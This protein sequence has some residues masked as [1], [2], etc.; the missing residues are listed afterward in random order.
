LS[1]PKPTIL[2]IGG[3]VITDKNGELS[4]K[5]GEIDRLT[6]EIREANVKNLIVVHGGGSFGHPAAERYAIKNGYK[7]ESQKIGFSQT[8]HYMTVLNGL[9]MDALIWHDVPSMS[10]TPSSCIITENGRI[11]SFE[12]A[13]LRTLMKMNFT[14]VLYGDAVFDTKIG[15][16]ILSGDQLVSALAL[17]FNATRIIMGVDEDGVYDAD[18]KAQKTAKLFDH[19]T[20]SELRR[21]QPKL[22]RIPVR[23]VTGGMYGKMTELIPAVEMNI[24]VTVVNASKP[25]YVYKALSG[26]TVKCTKIEKE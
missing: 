5:T 1:E 18:P 3:S 17:R 7:E 8:H 14:P 2:K 22:E 26:E 21:L 9:F 12:D 6:Q 15:F 4:A 10:I 23:D 16:T 24:P 11:R 19:L 13:P 20:L 25:G